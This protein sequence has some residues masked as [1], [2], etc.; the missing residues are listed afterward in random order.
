MDVRLRIKEMAK[1]QKIYNPTQLANRM[2]CAPTI[3]WRYWEGKQLP[4]IEML[5]RIADA[6]ECEPWDLVK[7]VNGKKPLRKK[8]LLNHK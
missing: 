1:G 2:E 4:G 5:Y 6:L 3:I 7:R 8:K